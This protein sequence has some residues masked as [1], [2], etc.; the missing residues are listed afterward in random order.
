MVHFPLVDIKPDDIYV[1][2][3][4][5][6]NLY[7]VILLLFLCQIA[8]KFYMDIHSTPWYEKRNELHQGEVWKPSGHYHRKW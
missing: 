2:S 3:L 6:F 7:L 5:M 4:L 8:G 1:K